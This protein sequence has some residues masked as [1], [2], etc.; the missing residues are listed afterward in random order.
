MTLVNQQR[1]PAAATIAALTINAQ[2]L[3]ATIQRHYVLTHGPII[4]V[5]R[6]I[7]R[8]WLTHHDG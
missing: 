7:L 6:R 4:W 5:L 3:Y 2:A 8:F 1:G